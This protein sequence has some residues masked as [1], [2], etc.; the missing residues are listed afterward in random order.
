[1][2]T[3][4]VR[5][6]STGGGGGGA[7]PFRCT[8][9]RGHDGPH[10]AL[11]VT[12]L[13]YLHEL[14]ATPGEFIAIAVAVA[15]VREGIASRVEDIRRMTMGVLDLRE[16]VRAHLEK[17]RALEAKACAAADAVPR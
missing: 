8:L 7:G 14:A 11:P 6:D 9:E 5:C 2:T 3:R 4:V 13:E 10:S 16:N 1:M 15:E 17:L 12:G